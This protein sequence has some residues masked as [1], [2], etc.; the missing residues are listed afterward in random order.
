MC[1]IKK[2]RITSCVCI[3]VMSMIFVL[4]VRLY[5]EEAENITYPGTEFN[6]YAQSENTSSWVGEPPY[7]FYSLINRVGFIRQKPV[8]PSGSIFNVKGNKQMISKGDDIYIR[9]TRNTSLT[10]GRYYTTYRTLKPIGDK[11]TNAHIGVQHYFTGVVEITQKEPRF[12]I[13]KVIQSFRTI[14][15][16]D[17]LMPYNN[18]TPKIILTESVKGLEGKI[19]GAEEHSTILGQHSVAFIDKGK[20]DGVVPGQQYSIYYQENAQFSP[21]TKEKIRLPPVDFGKV[22]VLHTEDTTS[23][24]LITQSDKTV[25]LGAKIHSPNAE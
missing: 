3:V 1:Y 5:A 9:E 6:K 24:V 13:A 20:K 15:I 16:D 22:L 2:F 18:R 23:T 10:L 7:F 12:V 19:F 21:R 25:Y 8:V 17:F 4:C 11:K 14:K